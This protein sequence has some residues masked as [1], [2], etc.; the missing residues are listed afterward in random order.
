MLYEDRGTLVPLTGPVVT[1]WFAALWLLMLP[2]ITNKATLSLAVPE[3]LSTVP[4]GTWKLLPGL[5][6]PSWALLKVGDCVS[7]GAATVKF[8]VCYSTGLLAASLAKILSLHDA[9]PIS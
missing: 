1:C 3:K 2:V 7:G 8:Q 4:K 5:W 9:L 6:L